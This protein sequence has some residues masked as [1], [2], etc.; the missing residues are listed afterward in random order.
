MKE[1]VAEEMGKDM[2]DVTSVQMIPLAAYEMA[3]ER[4]E[5]EKDRMRTDFQNEKNRMRDDF[6]KEK[7]EMRDRYQKIIKWVCAALATLI[8]CVFGA[9]IWFFSSYDVLGVS[10]DGDGLN[11]YAYGT[12]QGDV[13]YGAENQND[14]PEAQK[15]P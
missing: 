6:Q 2:N 7:T 3:H 10:Q 15:N 9:L 11:N 14:S 5:N 8:I 1:K 4:N 13:I 12:E